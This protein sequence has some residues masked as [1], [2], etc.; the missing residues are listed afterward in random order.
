LCDQ[1][2]AIAPRFRPLR[3]VASQWNRPGD[4]RAAHADGRN[5]GR[6]AA[7]EMMHKE[8]LGSPVRCRGYVLPCPVGVKLLQMVDAGAP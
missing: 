4:Q 6:P 1:A 7:V 3:L 8:R 2:D 5:E